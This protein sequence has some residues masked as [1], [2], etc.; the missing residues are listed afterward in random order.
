MANA[1][2][3]E[4][5]NTQSAFGENMTIVGYTDADDETVQLALKNMGAKYGK[6]AKSISTRKSEEA[7]DVYKTSPVVNPGPIKRRS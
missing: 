3:N 5:M 6:G 7:L 1:R 4:H 2:S